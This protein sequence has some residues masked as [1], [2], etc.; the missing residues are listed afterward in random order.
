MSIRNDSTKLWC[1]LDTLQMRETN[2]QATDIPL[3]STHIHHETAWPAGDAITPGVLAWVNTVG[4]GNEDSDGALGS[5]SMPSYI[6][7]VDM[8]DFQDPDPRPMMTSPLVTNGV[9]YTHPKLQGGLITPVGYRG[10]FDPALPMSAQWTAGW[11]NFDPQGWCDTPDSCGVVLGPGLGLGRTAYNQNYNRTLCSDTLYYLTGTY[12]VDS[13]YSLTIPAGTVIRGDTASTL[14]ISRGAQIFATGTDECPIVFTSMKPACT[15]GPGDWGGIVILGE[16]PVNQVNPL[17]EG[18]IIGG[19]Y[20]GNDPHDNSGILRYVRIE[21]PGYRFQLNNEINGLTMGGVG[22]GTEIHHIQVSYS[23]DDSYE[24]FGGTVNCK[25]L[26]AYAGTDDE[27]DTDFG[28]SGKLQYLFGLRDIAYYDPNGQ[29]NGFESDNEGDSPY[30]AKPTTRPVFCNV[31]LVGPERVDSMVGDYIGTN[32]QYGAVLRR[33]TM[34]SIYNSCIMGYPWGISIRNDST[35][36]WCN[37]DTLQIRQ[38]NI[39]AG[40]LPGM[41]SHIHHESAWPA[42]DPIP[43]GVLAWINRAGYGNQDSDGAPGSTSL[44]SYID[45]VDM[46]DI[47]NPD[48]RPTLASP[49]VTNGT[50]Y[51]YPK[52]QDAFF[53]SVPYRGAF[54]PTKNLDETW[55]WKWTNFNPCAEPYYVGIDD[56]PEI[57]PA[58]RTLLGQNYPNPFRMTTNVRYAVPQN[59]H[60]SL[61]VYNVQGQEVATLVDEEKAAGNYEVSFDTKKLAAGAYFYT[62][63]GRGFSETRKMILTK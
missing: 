62:L 28:Y 59:G 17:I 61:K 11:A 7:L 25:Y 37:L 18:G 16:A 44:P 33:H 2:L 10:A 35:K 34:T 21:F 51:S 46:H 39:Q 5:T 58:T 27:F 56:M 20:G 47:H 19:T 1:N 8:H 52:L 45:L 31:T 54:D 4:Y 14:V 29:S 9:D 48:P 38:T 15:R 43:P 26:V 55:I 36:L 13:T 57:V 60:I 63:K 22:D 49:L 24:W 32:Y 23:Y 3:G 53:D 6:Q 30:E 40:N 12:Y 42:S 41:W 50:N